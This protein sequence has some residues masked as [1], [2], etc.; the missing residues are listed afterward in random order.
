LN[1]KLISIDGKTLSEGKSDKVNLENLVK[2]SYI[3]QLENQ[4]STIVYVH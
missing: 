1:F 2:G 3:L 4:F